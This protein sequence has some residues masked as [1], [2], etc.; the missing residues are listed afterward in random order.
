MACTVVASHQVDSTRGSSEEGYLVA[1][2][3]LRQTV[4]S[5]ASHPMAL[6]LRIYWD[7]ACHMDCKVVGEVAQGNS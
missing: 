2:Y 4:R 3:S 1:T 6:K 5:T 7:A